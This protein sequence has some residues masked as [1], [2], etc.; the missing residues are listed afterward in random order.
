[1]RKNH[2]AIPM[3][4]WERDKSDITPTI[5][6]QAKQARVDLGWRTDLDDMN[7]K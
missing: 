6:K 5:C 4:I 1:M 2:Y 3:N 7:N